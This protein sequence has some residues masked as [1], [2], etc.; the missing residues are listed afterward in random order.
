MLRSLINDPEDGRYGQPKPR[1]EM[2]QGEKHHIDVQ[3]PAQDREMSI[4]TALAR[5]KEES[6]VRAAEAMAKEAAYQH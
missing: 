4:R 1:E 6:L 2:D 5:A 3:A